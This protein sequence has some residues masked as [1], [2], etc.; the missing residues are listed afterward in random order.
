MELTVSLDGLPFSVS[1]RL[2]SLLNAELLARPITLNGSDV[3]FNFRDKS[4][5]PESGGYH[6]V[7]IRLYRQHGAWHFDY[8][9]D[10]C[11]VGGPYPELVKDLDFNFPEKCGYMLYGGYCKA[12]D[13]DELY[14]VWEQNFIYYYWDGAFDEVEISL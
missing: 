3:I 6:P 1:P 9:T 10:F 13:C 8:I 7:E 11:Y 14:K 5:S 12:E 4:Y 2:I